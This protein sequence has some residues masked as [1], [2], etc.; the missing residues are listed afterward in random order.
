MPRSTPAPSRIALTAPVIALGLLA[1]VAPAAAAPAEPPQA[2]QEAQVAPIVDVPW[3]IAHRGASAYRPEHTLPAY[4]LAVRQRADVLEPD[5]VPTSDGHLIARHENELS[6]STDVADRAEFADRRTT[7][8]ID[9]RQVTGWFSEDFTL[10]E[11]KRLRA[12]ERLPDI[13]PRSARHDG[14]YEVATFE[15]VLDLRDDAARRTG[16][17][18][19]VMPEIKHGAYF[20][21]IGLDAEALLA[22]VLDERGLNHPDAPV[23]VQSFEPDSVRELG[24]RVEV[25]LIQLIG[26]RQ[27]H[28]TTPEALDEIA[29]YADAIGPDLRWVLPI[30]DDGLPGEPTPLVSDAHDRGLLVTPW[31]LRSENAFLP[32]GYR[33]GDDPSAHGDHRGYYI[34]VLR[35]GVDGVFTDNP[36]HLYKARMHFLKEQR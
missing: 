13:R 8:T 15:E 21:S 34:E 18:I 7:K 19:M 17:D 12:V 26:S 14:K 32:A 4:E 29:T 27:Q 6:D 24:E 33:K 9:G 3:V 25:T 23:A 16:R 22:E 20:D 35:T 31:T 2:R 10:T 1:G 5:L 30:G 28:L 36:D 11:V